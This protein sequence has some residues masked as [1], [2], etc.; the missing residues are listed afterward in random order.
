[1]PQPSAPPGTPE[2][3]VVHLV[4]EDSALV[5]EGNG[6]ILGYPLVQP[7]SPHLDACFEG[8]APVKDR[9]VVDVAKSCAH[10]VVG[11]VVV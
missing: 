3:E 2:L 5:L 1:M 10:F 6:I 4:G 7:D 9:Q 11:V 8:V